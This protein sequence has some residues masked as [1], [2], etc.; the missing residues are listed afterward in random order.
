MTSPLDL[1]GEPSAAMRLRVKLTLAALLRALGD[2]P[3]GAEK[4]EGLASGCLFRLSAWNSA[5][6]H[7]QKVCVHAPALA[8][9]MK[10][11]GVDLP[12]EQVRRMLMR[13]GFEDHRPRTSSGRITVLSMRPERWSVTRA[14][15]IKKMA[16]LHRLDQ[17]AEE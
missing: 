5:M 8:C 11:L 12:P 13:I 2:D 4:E 14:A 17:E 1:G 10:R 15:L 9:A 7:R 3:D 16:R 6:P